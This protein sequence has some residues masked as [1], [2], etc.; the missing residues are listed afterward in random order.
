M[1]HRYSFC[2]LLLAATLVGC[3]KH[4]VHKSP[5]AVPDEDQRIEALLKQMTLEEKVG[6][7]NQLDGPWQSSDL[8]GDIRA[9]RISSLFGVTT[10]EQ[11]EHLQRIA[12]EESRLGIP[13]VFARDVIHGFHTVFP[14]P[15]GQSTTWNP[16]LIE[17]GAHEVAKEATQVGIRWTFSPMVDIARD[18]RWGRIAEGYGEDTYLTSLFG[19]A[20]VRGY[21]GQDLAAPNSLAACVKHFAGYSASEGGR[22]YNTTWIPEVQL[23]DVYLPPFKACIDAGC[24]TIMCSFNDINGIPSVANQ[25]LNLDILREEWGFDGMMVTDWGA[26]QDLLA[27]GYANDSVAATLKSLDAQMEMDMAARYYSELL[28]RLVKEGRVSEKRVDELV[29]SVL[30]LKIRLGLFEHPYPYMPTGK[31][32]FFAP[33]ALAAAQRTCEESAVLL[34]NNGVLPLFTQG[35]TEKTKRIFIC[36][37]LADNQHD[38]N[39]TWCLDAVDSVV[40]TPA[41]AFRQPEKYE[42]VQYAGMEVC[43]QEGFHWSRERSDE[44]I[45]NLKKQAAKADVVLFFA[46][47]E[48]MISG[49]AKTRAHITLPGDQTQQLE[50]IR[51]TGVP[52]VMIVMAGRPLTIGKEVEMADAVIYAY[53]GGTMQGPALY[54]ILTGVVNPSGKLTTTFVQAEGQIPFYYNHKNTGRPTGPVTNYEDI[55]VNAGQFSI[56]SCTYWLEYAKDP[57]FPFGFGL[58][59]TTFQYADFQLSASSMSANGSLTA[60]CTV[61][62]TG[63]C[64]GQE[65]VQLYIR[66]KVGSICRP[67]LELKGFEKIA[68]EPG[69]SRT[70]E[71]EI[72]PQMLEY[73]H[74]AEQ[75][76][77]GADGAY[78]LSAEPGEFLVWI[79]PNSRDLPA[80][81]SF[82]L[83]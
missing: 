12:V 11:A 58:S 53:H 1:R 54:N 40:I 65:V 3:S 29:R 19:A 51:E 49:E 21:Q 36:G 41:M 10:A 26:I 56:G 76:Q 5:Y 17:L 55:P 77:P 24:A 43:C 44:N 42:L 31:P 34:K 75:I 63:S 8:E 60:S 15:L 47:E 61:T 52:V 48:A 59:Y 6:Q 28:P 20:T 39:G 72:T 35:A 45:A 13:L 18:P 2:I 66:D 79:A 83:N 57:L 23:R 81:A 46:G 62:N 14:I 9:G 70:V 69:E 7:L 71:F 74:F 30:R 25:H 64:A 33:E 27:H 82:M 22:D 73:W 16:T 37:P 78:T 67:L 4:T 68:L 32:E 80:P 50:A 38:Q